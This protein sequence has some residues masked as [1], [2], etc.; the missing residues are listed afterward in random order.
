M[1]SRE[2]IAESRRQ[3]NLL[4][5]IIMELYKILLNLYEKFKDSTRRIHGRQL[6]QAHVGKLLI[7]SESKV[8][9]YESQRKLYINII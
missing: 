2:S 5:H 7:K 3:I 4:L 8:L 1:Y 9:H 6:E